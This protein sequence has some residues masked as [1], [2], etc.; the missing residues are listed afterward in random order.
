MALRYFYLL[1]L[2]ILL[3]GCSKN[4]DSIPPTPPPPFTFTTLKVNGVNNGF[5]YYGINTS[6]IVKVSFSAPVNRSAVTNSFFLKDNNGGTISYNT[7]YENNDSTVVIQP[8]SPLNYIT[9]Y[10]LSVT[11]DIKSQAGSSLQSAITVN[12]LTAIDS[13]DKFSI[14]T[15]D[16]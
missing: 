9:K 3:H 5:T 8:S 2:I 4:T 6:S 12:F 1:C 16:A 15:D 10:F 11:T 7:S 14:I 13:S